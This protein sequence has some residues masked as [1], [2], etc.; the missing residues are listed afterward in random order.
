M[1]YIINLFGG[2][3]TGKS[4]TAAGLFNLLKLKDIKTELVTE[5]AKD[6]TYE[7]RSFTLDNQ[8]YVS[9]K[10]HH[11]IWRVLEYWKNK[12]VKNGFIVTDSPFILG[13]MYL[14]PSKTAEKFKDFVLAEFREFHNINIFLN[15]VKKYDPIGRNQTEDE[16]R[17]IDSKIK[18]FLE[19]NNI[20]HVNIIGDKNAH[21]SISNY[22]KESGKIENL[23][24][25]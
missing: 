24:G 8:F 15:R 21:E 16:A 2:P 18:I 14:K 22:L 17:D 4:T 7:H 5:F 3:G 1:I 12:N 9:A 11:R 13:L 20:F 23:K 6:A 10:Q 19:N 25:D